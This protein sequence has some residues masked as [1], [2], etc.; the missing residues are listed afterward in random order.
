[1]HT[2]R[3]LKLNNRQPL[4][5]ES[6]AYVMSRDQRVHD[7]HAL[8]AAQESAISSSLPL[9]VVFN[10]TPTAGVRSKEHFDFMLDGLRDVISELEALHIGFIMTVGDAVKTLP[11]I[12]NNLKPKEVFFD[13]NPLRGA[14]K[15]Q[16]KVAATVTVPCTVVDTH[17]I[18]PLWVLSDKEE[19]A[20]HTIRNKIHKNLESWLIEPDK[21]IDHPHTF[22]T[23]IASVSLEKARRLVT[24]KKTGMK[25]AFVPGEKAAQ[26]HLES[27][28]G[29][30]LQSYGKDRNVP[31]VDGQSNLSPYLHF[32][33]I[34]ALRVALA[35]VDVAPEPPLLFIRGKLASYE[36]EP[37]QI[38]S[39]NA[40]LEEL[41]VRKELA[42]NYCFYNHNYDSLDGAKDWAKKS[43]AEH[44]DDVREFVYTRDQWESALTH[45]DAW[46]AAQQEMMQT[47]KMHGYMR[48]YWAKKILEWSNS[49]EE[50]IQSAIYLNDHYSID[51]GD[52]NGYTG[53]MWSI[54]GVH[55]RPWFDR[56]V[57]GKIRYMNIGGLQRRFKVEEYI[58]RWTK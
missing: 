46:N 52:P 15:M 33:H 21:I 30:G 34:S 22:I 7:N 45:D 27:F 53:I 42:D 43:L 38:D 16:K 44:T 11:E 58:A 32:G 12:I 8:L 2:S 37:T 19:Y 3:L 36:G 55:D 6:V 49:P 4:P 39:I 54:A 51:G 25:S 26:E 9:V 18:I 35:L 50:A 10:L 17:N 57:F 48:M 20:A 13:F 29:A 1:M 47:G 56:S 5:G 41:I 23:E 31:T 24:A 40:L 28:I 14:R